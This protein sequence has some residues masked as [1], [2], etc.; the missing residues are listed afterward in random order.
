[1]ALFIKIILDREI[2]LDAQT[3]DEKNTYSFAIIKNYYHVYTF[4]Y[5]YFITFITMYITTS[6][7]PLSLSSIFTRIYI[8]SDENYQRNKY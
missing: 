4:D 2:Q 1:M 7:S 8:V 3:Y 5:K 6:P